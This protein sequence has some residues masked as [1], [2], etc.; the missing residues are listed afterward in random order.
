VHT[1]HRAANAINGWFVAPETSAYKFHM[2]CD[3][4]CDFYMGLNTS[5]PLKTTHLVHTRHK[6]NRANFRIIYDTSS[7]WV[8]LTKGD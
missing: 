6:G 3:D 8:N 1:V 2:T 4:L 7:N 5:D